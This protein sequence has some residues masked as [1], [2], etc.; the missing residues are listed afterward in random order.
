[1]GRCW[2]SVEHV[3]DTLRLQGTREPIDR[4]GS[5]VDRRGA[6]CAH[7]AVLRR[8]SSAISLHTRKPQQLES[9]CPH[10]PGRPRNQGRLAGPHAHR[11]IDH[12]PCGDVVQNHRG[13]VAIRNTLGNR[14]DVFRLAYQKFREPPINCQ[15]GYPLAWFEPGDTS[16]GGVHYAGDLITWNEG[17][18]RRI[19]IISGEHEQ[20]RR[21]HSRGAHAHTQLSGTG[22]LHW[23][24]HNPECLRAALSR[25]HHC[26]IC[27]RHPCTLLAGPRRR[28]RHPMMAHRA[29]EV[30]AVILYPQCMLFAGFAGVV[31]P[32]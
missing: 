17:Y 29:S 27:F 6:E 32:D 21:P 7:G 16:A 22:R 24:L 3:V 30:H 8:R 26:A 28:A 12:L 13:G 18:F 5:I 15:R 9:G 14:K 4:S 25:H 19:S 11:P 1:M 31:K 20:I 23:Q 10:S 2:H